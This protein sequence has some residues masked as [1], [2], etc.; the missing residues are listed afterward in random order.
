VENFYLRPFTDQAQA[1]W[2]PRL[3]DAMLLRYSMPSEVVPARG[4]LRDPN[5]NRSPSSDAFGITYAAV[6]RCTRTDPGRRSRPLLGERGERRK[7][8]PRDSKVP[9]PRSKSIMNVFKRF[10]WHPLRE[11][12]ALLQPGQKLDGMGHAELLTRLQTVYPDKPSE[13]L[14]WLYGTLSILDTKATGLLAFNAIL[15]ALAS[16]ALPTSGAWSAAWIMLLLSLLLLGRACLECL[17][18]LN[19]G[20]AF[21]GRVVPKASDLATELADL[22]QHVDSRTLD[23]SF[24]RKWSI[25]GFVLLVAGGVALTLASQTPPALLQHQQSR[26]PL[27][28]PRPVPPDSAKY[29]LAQGAVIRAQSGKSAFPFEVGNADLRTAL[30]HAAEFSYAPIS[31]FKVGAL[32]LGISGNIYFGANLEMPSGPLGATLHAEQS[33]ILNAARHGEKEV[34]ALAINAPP[35]GHCRQFLQELPNPDALRILVLPRESTEQPFDVTL[36]SLLPRPFGPRHLGIRAHLLSYDPL[37]SSS[38]STSASQRRSLHA[39]L[40]A[41][42]APYT[43]RRGAAVAL[44][45]DGFAIYATS[46][47]SVAYNPTVPVSIALLSAICLSS[48]HEAPVT[49]I[50]LSYDPSTLAGVSDFDRNVLQR[51]FP[52]APILH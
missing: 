26:S 33:A 19:V 37:P 2:Q 49:S 47:E 51:A 46:A 35:C 16:I 38:G 23:F 22:V 5:G 48:L 28:F 42:H 24:A 30:T 43:S 15:A 10:F 9:S 45:A 1:E 4:S 40:S 39:A 44:F 25:L 6:G 12:G 50:L 34:V 13:Q 32:C 21:L 29:T 3:H 7:S 14:G 41:S 31:N 20:Y 11:T 52:D 18:I 8:D 27:Q 17:Y 36:G